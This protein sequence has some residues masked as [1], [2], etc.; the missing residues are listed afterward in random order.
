MLIPPAGIPF[1]RLAARFTGARQVRLNISGKFNFFK[2]FLSL[3]RNR[4]RPLFRRKKQ[5]I[6]DLR[7]L[8]GYKEICYFVSANCFLFQ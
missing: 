6:L 1:K 7:P 2:F 8:P 4:G 3:A 5:V